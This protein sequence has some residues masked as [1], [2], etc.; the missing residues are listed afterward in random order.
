MG[1]KFIT[2]RKCGNP[3]TVL[4]A[5]KKPAAVKA[6]CR[7]CGWVGEM[8]NNHKLAGWLSKR[9]PNKVPDS[10]MSA[11]E[12]TE[13]V[14]GTSKKGGSRKS[15]Q[16]GGDEEGKLGKEEFEDSEAIEKPKE[17][18]RPSREPKRGGGVDEDEETE[19]KKGTKR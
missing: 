14:E 7:A 1:D 10:L 12:A 15:K 4:Y 13:K 3:E 6:V 8:D 5:Q 11:T 16:G 2:C 19:G 9:L 18:K 17:G